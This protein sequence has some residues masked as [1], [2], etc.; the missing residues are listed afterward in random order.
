MRQLGRIGWGGILSWVRVALAAT[1]VVLNYALELTGSWLSYGFLGLYLAYALVVALRARRSNG[2]VELL[3][4]FGDTVYLLVVATYGGEPIL[5]LAALFFLMF[6]A[7]RGFS[8]ILFAPVAALGAVLLTDPAAVPAAFTGLFMDKMVGFAKLYFPRSDPLV[9]TLEAFAVY[10][11]GFAARPVGAAIFGH[12]GDGCVHCRI[13][14]DLKTAE[15]V[16]MYRKFME[17]AADLVVRYGGSLS[18]EHGDGQ[19]RA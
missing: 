1:A 19:A 12:F 14:F 8:V 15:G 17:E 4:L 5:W 9:G 13:T 7:Y 16:R 3:A 18:G 11:V 10:A 2:L 6:V